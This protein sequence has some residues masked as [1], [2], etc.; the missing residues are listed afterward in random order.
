MKIRQCHLLLLLLLLI[1]TVYSIR[2]NEVMYN[3]FGEDDNREFVEIYGT[4]NLSGY[5]IGDLYVNDSLEIMKF[6]PGNLSLVVESGFNYSGI[7]CSV[8]SAGATIGNNLRNSGDS[9]F[10]YRNS[11]LVDRLSYNASLANNNNHSLELVNGSWNESCEEEGSPG[12]EN[13]IF[14]NNDSDNGNDQLNISEGSCFVILNLST[15]KEVY[16][17]GESV[18]INNS[19][20]NKGFDFIIEYW[21]E[22]LEGEIVKSKVNTSNTNIKSYTPRIKAKEKALLVKNRLVFVDC[23]NSNELLENEKVVIAKHSDYE[24][25]ESASEKSTTQKTVTTEK[26]NNQNAS[27]KTIVSEGSKIISFYTRNQ[28]YNKSINLY[29]NINATEADDIV[30]ISNK[31]EYKSKFNGTRNMKFSVEPERGLN[32]FVLQIRQGERLI[33]TASLLVNLEA[34][35]EEST[36]QA[37]EDEALLAESKE[38]SNQGESSNEELNEITGSVVYESPNSKAIKFA[39][40][41]VVILVGLV[42]LAIYISKRR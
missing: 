33:D 32:L 37:K 19:L 36:K 35:D 15:D 28:K 7:N 34:V 17:D 30:L 9:V 27:K 22:D 31:G 8:Y 4:N 38:A 40:Y 11:E 2:I 5:T 20:S 42:A 14:V 23:D 10:L 6:V 26:D 3:P 18:K 41:F 25:E 39:P 29:A 24:E 12:R 16:E 21:I 1:P 13:C